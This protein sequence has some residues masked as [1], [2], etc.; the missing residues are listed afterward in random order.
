MRTSTGLT[1][2]PGGVRVIEMA[3]AEDTLFVRN[4]RP[5]G[6]V[7]HFDGVRYKL[8]HRGHRQ[9]SVALPIDAASDGQI[10]RW[11]QIGQLEKISRD[12][13]MKLG[14]RT[15]D[16]LPNEY[17]KRPMREGRGVETPLRRAD[18]DTTGSLSVVDDGD[19]S[20]TVNS[21]LS[22]K[23]AGDLM[24]TEEELD[25]PEFA[26]QQTQPNYPSRHRED[27]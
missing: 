5:N 10:S 17:L 26:N 21:T 9:D 12:S 14:S 3:K 11:L 1:T 18:S 24:S 19:V 22:Q 16:V 13:F 2:F 23:W 8:E 20:R 15:V 25:S 27:R 6:I 4:G 7:F